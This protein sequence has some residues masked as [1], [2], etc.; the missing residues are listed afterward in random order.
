MQNKHNKKLK[1][2][3]FVKKN[4]FNKSVRLMSI[5]YIIKSIYTLAPKIT[6]EH[7]DKIKAADK[8]MH[9]TQLPRFE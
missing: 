3:Y 5:F 6:N 9:Y 2:K 4:W 1:S 7:L 8:Y